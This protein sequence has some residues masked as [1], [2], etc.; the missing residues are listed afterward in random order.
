[1]ICE[2]GDAAYDYCFRVCAPLMMFM[3]SAPLT[4]FDADADTRYYDCH[5]PLAR[6][7]F[8]RLIR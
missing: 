6:L 3:L 2:R 7:I 5:A 1:M 8:E 4:L